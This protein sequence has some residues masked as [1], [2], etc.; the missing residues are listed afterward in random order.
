MSTREPL[1]DAQVDQ[2]LAALAGWARTGSGAQA[3]I[4]KTFRFA[5]YAATIAFV[6]AVAAVAEA[7]DHHPDLGVHWG[8]VVVRYN[9]HSASAVTAL[10][11]E[12]ARRVDALRP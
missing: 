1:T 9:T 6:N 8:R 10:D 3:A 7:L 5:D 2:A 4:E 12:S 11:I